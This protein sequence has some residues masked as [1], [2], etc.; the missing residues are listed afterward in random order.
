[1]TAFF[2]SVIKSI[3]SARLQRCIVPKNFD[4][5]IQSFESSKKRDK[6]FEKYLNL[7]MEDEGVKK[8]MLY[9]GLSQSDLEDSYKTLL[10]C[11]A[12]QWVRGHYQQSLIWSL[13]CPHN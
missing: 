5:I 8:I 7:C 1:M 2:G 6:A 9:Y 12:G 13:T 4:E 11:G 10:M 3:K